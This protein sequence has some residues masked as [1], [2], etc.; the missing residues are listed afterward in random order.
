MTYREIQDALKDRRIKA[1]AEA[2][3]LHRQTVREIRDGKANPTARTLDKL[4]VYLE[5]RK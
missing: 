4:R 2:S 3:G 1:V 5:G